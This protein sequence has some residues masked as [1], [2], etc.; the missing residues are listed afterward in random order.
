[1]LNLEEIWQTKK[2]RSGIIKKYYLTGTPIVR[3]AP[4][5]VLQMFK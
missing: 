4:T 5:L 3:G 2:P 1:M